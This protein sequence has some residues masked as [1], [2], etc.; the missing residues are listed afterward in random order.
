MYSGIDRSTV[1][2][3][4][5]DICLQVVNLQGVSQDKISNKYDLNK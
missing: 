2:W 3:V 1:Q 4:I 5:G